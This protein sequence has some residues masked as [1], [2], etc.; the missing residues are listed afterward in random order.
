MDKNREE[1]I[2]NLKADITEDEQNLLTHVLSMLEDGAKGNSPEDMPDS[3]ALEFLNK[4]NSALT[5]M[6]KVAF[7]ALT[8][9]GAEE[10]TT[11]M[12]IN[13]VAQMALMAGGVS[14][15]DYQVTESMKRRMD[16]E[17]T[18]NDIVKSI[19]ESEDNG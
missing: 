4:C 19:E 3:V 16:I 5:V 10:E 14:F 12:F 11:A 13:M 7:Q 9:Q 6:T 17:P 8:S 1:I 18:I 15:Y 2:N